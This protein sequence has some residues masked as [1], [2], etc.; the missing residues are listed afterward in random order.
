VNEDLFDQFMEAALRRPMHESFEPIGRVMFGS[1]RCVLWVDSGN[2]QALISRTFSASAPYGSSLPGFVL[3]TRNVI[4]VRGPTQAP[5]PLSIPSGSPQLL[6]PLTAG[7]VVRAVVQIVQVPGAPTFSEIDHRTASFL[8]RKFE[9]YGNAIFTSHSIGAIALALY[10]H[11]VRPL[12]PLR[13]IRGHFGCQCAE[14]WQCDV[15]RETGRRIAEAGQPETFALRDAGIVGSAALTRRALNVPESSQLESFDARLD[16]PGPLL[17]ALHGLGRKCWAVI[18]S[19]RDTPFSAVDSAQL[20]ALLPF[21][22]RS[23]VGFNASTDR[24]NYMAQLTE[25]VTWAYILTKEPDNFHKMVQAEV[26]RL[27]ECNRALLYIIRSNKKEFKAFFTDTNPLSQPATRPHTRSRSHV[28]PAPPSHIRDGSESNVSKGR[29]RSQRTG[30]QP[31]PDTQGSSGSAVPSVRVFP[32]GRGIAGA[33]MTLKQ[34]EYVDN[35]RDSQHWDVDVDCDP[36]YQ[37]T[38]LLALPICGASDEVLGSVICLSKNGNR[39]F[40]ESDI[41]ILTGVNVF[42]GIAIQN[43]KTYRRIWKLNKQM[44]T[45]LRS[46]RGTKARDRIGDKDKDGGGTRPRKGSGWGASRKRVW[47]GCGGCKQEIR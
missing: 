25:L 42:V 3:R 5:D 17:L 18:L 19:G 8:I 13:L 37:P 11:T 43:R 46:D 1:P 30:L 41:Q 21:I 9:T 39:E 23:F 2:G 32:M 20:N 31:N 28:D 14:C 22:L 44:R 40:G 45:L 47:V 7:G 16:R 15:V 26:A 12:D 6:F 35:P 36:R 38:L 34:C 33:C 10:T 29:S 4:Q 24:A 27:L